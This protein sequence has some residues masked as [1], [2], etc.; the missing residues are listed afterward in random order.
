MRIK[1][2]GKNVP[3][4]SPL[5]IA[6]NTLPYIFARM[7]LPPQ[8]HRFT[9]RVGTQRGGGEPPAGDLPRP[10][11]EVG[12]PE[13]GTE[14]QPSLF[15]ALTAAFWAEP[16]PEEDVTEPEVEPEPDAPDQ[17]DAPDLW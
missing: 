17:D 8:H 10:G 6:C 2:I 9:E 16:W 15:D 1:S 7:G 12:T 3:S 14:P 5:N 4:A 11:G 13:P